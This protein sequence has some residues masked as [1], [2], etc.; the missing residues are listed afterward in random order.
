MVAVKEPG[1]LFGRD[2]AD[3]HL[4]LLGCE[5]SGRDAAQRKLAANGPISLRT[6]LLEVGVRKD[7]IKEGLKVYKPELGRRGQKKPSQGLGL[8]RMLRKRLITQL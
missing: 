1:K 8:N 6:V 7:R 3:A 4:D 5:W 2:F